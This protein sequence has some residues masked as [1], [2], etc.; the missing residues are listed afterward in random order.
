MLAEWGKIHT[1][2]SGIKTTLLKRGST[3][4]P[5]GK[6][7]LHQCGVQLELHVGWRWGGWRE[8]KLS[9][10]ENRL[11]VTPMPHTQLGTDGRLVQI[12]KCQPHRWASRRLHIL[13][14]ISLQKEIDEPSMIGNKGWCN[15]TTTSP[16]PLC[17]QPCLQPGT[18]DINEEHSVLKP[19]LI[20][21]VQLVC[22]AIC[23]QARKNLVLGWG[24]S[25]ESRGFTA[26]LQPQQGIFWHGP[27]IIKKGQV[28]LLLS[29]YPLNGPI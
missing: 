6:Q 23:R 21:V 12:N 5:K 8:W 2:W 19:S 16:P 22:S 18:V 24:C 25:S 3:K 29:W 11:P 15:L 7:L 1:S 9:L 26:T 10:G 4:C 13:S 27:A 14:P 17:F 20:N 28:T